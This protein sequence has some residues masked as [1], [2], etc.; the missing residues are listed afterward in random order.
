MKRLKDSAALKLR[1]KERDYFQ[2]LLDQYRRETEHLHEQ[3]AHAEETLRFYS[4]AVKYHTHYRGGY[5]LNRSEMKMSQMEVDS[6]EL[7]RK[8]F[9]KHKKK[10]TANE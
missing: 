9:K 2:N 3:L 10:C 5:G 7:A 1:T 6:G 8:Y 4:A